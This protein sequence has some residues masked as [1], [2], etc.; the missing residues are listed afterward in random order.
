MR[1]NNVPSNSAKTDLL[2]IL[3]FLH[4]GREALKPGFDF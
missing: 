1:A 4:V 3:L 2:M